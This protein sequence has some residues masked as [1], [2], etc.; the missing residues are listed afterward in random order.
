MAESENSKKKFK[1]IKIIDFCD[2]F[3]NINYDMNSCIV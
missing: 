3:L 1:K 2:I